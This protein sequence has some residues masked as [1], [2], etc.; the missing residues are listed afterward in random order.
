MFD[1]SKKLQSD[2]EKYINKILK[3]IKNITKDNFSGLYIHGSLAMGGFN[4]ER[5]DVDVLVVVRDSLNSLKQQKLA[6]CLLALSNNP[7]PLEISFLTQN[8]LENWTHPSPY[9]FHYSEAWR[10]RFQMELATGFFQALSEKGHKEDPD[11]AAHITILNHRGIC[12]EGPPIRDVFPIIPRA[13]YLSSILADY[14]DCLENIEKDPIY[15]VLNLVRVYWFIKDGVISSKQEAGE[16]GLSSF[17]KEFK[18]T[19]LKVTESYQ[20]RH[21]SDFHKEELRKV[22][23]YMKS[24][25][26]KYEKELTS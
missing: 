18:G 9:E 19:F 10:E 4:P 3:E 17:P 24:E 15:C 5:S 11:L 14:R 16:Y 1:T 25:I 21:L 12:I 26:E 6:E 13:H 8:Q 23:N 20:G 22:R 7:Y 2:I